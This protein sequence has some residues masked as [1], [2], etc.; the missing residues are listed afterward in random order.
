MAGF[1]ER[2]KSSL[3]LQLSFALAAGVLLIAVLAGGFSFMAAY[4][5]ANEL[6]DDTLREV[7]ALLAGQGGLAPSAVDGA[8][9]HKDSHVVAQIVGDPR[10]A[11]PF[12]AELPEGLST[13]EL[14]GE[15]YRVLVH[16]LGDGRRIAVAQE[17]DLRDDAAHASA[18]RTVLPMLLLMVLLLIIVAGVVRKL[19]GP[20]AA[21]AQ[22]LDQRGRHAFPQLQHAHDLRPMDEHA[23][24]AELR[25][26]IAALNRMLGRLA[27]A[28]AAQRRFVADAAHELRTPMAAIALQAERLSKAAMSPEAAQRLTT[29]REG[30]ARGTALLDQ[31][32]SLAR[33]QAQSPEDQRHTPL[34][35][36]LLRVVED[37]LP[38]AGAAGIDLGLTGEGDPQLLLR[39]ADLY[40]LVKNLVDNAIRF[41]PP[42][43]RVDI[44]VKVAD[45]HVVLR[46][47]DE[48][49]GIPANEQ[50]QVF[51]PFY[52]GAG[53]DTPG[54]GLGLAIVAAI[55]A[56]AGG[57]C[58]LS[59]GAPGRATG[60]CVEVSI[61]F[62]PA[63]GVPRTA[64]L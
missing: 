64:N 30:I 50:Q 13:R 9:P 60:L 36:V 51:A 39:Q 62:Q 26:F 56:Q 47:S 23:L 46:V 3:Q 28:V 41:S 48:G 21:A 15:S 5:E 55:V 10:G 20:I 57:N 63:D 25:P 45:E 34:R 14:K 1:Q 31:M 59:N 58:A 29:L 8:N 54:T 22:E 19:V 42:G 27:A 6:Q 43:S 49:P 18:V 7:S 44:D 37:L 53:Q 24:P 38:Q 12:P 32:L 4:G 40:M 2:L 61:P 35:P 33:A 16:T 11:L 17:T 52:R